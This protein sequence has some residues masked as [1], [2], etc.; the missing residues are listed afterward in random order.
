MGVFLGSSKSSE[1]VFKI[2]EACAKKVAEEPRR[3][4]L[5]MSSIGDPCERKLWLDLNG[6]PRE[7]FSGQLCRILQNGHDREK[8]II[9]E[10]KIPGHEVDGTQM[11]FSEF[12]LFKGHCD[13][14]I[15]GLT[16]TTGPHV[17]EIKTANA[18]SFK[19]MKT[20]GIKTASPK[21]WA[22]IQ[23]YMGYAGLKRGQFIVENKN[24][25]ELYP[26]TVE[27]EEETF[28]ALRAKAERIIKAQEA[29]A[30]I[31]QPGSAECDRCN[32]SSN[33]DNPVPFRNLKKE[34]E[35]CLDCSYFRAKEKSAQNL[36]GLITF[37]RTFLEL[38]ELSP[39]WECDL[40]N[41]SKD[42][43]AA[44][45]DIKLPEHLYLQEFKTPNHKQGWQ[46]L[47]DFYL[48]HCEVKDWEREPD[49]TK[50]PFQAKSASANFCAHPHHRAKLFTLAGCPDHS[51]NSVAPF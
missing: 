9:E 48:A 35:P 8:R 42:F 24:N 22:Q 23:C 51:N 46:A 15:S 19:K 37:C 21:Y 30:R 25:Q 29:P 7:P 44:R 18:A 5:G 1:I 4:Y 32:F 36:L 38:D 45:P 20:C 41:L 14:I 50:T 13:G 49:S 2:Y 17:L 11:E 39:V 43:Y 26:E 12:E 40:L 47:H 16:K 6:Q 10:L 28:N 31:F 34:E 3:G 33:C 27:F